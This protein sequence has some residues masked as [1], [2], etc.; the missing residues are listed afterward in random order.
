MSTFLQYFES[1]LEYMRHALSEFERSHP[2][3]AKSLRLTAGRSMDP[4]VQRLADSVALIAARL[5]KRLD[6]T[7]PEISLDILRMT[8]PGFL[9][10]APSYATIQPDPDSEPLDGPETLARGTN[11][12]FE[13]SGTRKCTFSVA[14]NVSLRPLVLRNLRFEQAPFTF[15]APP[16]ITGIE[17]ALCLEVVAQSGE[18]PVKPLIHG[19]LEIYLPSSSSR[20]NSLCEALAGAVE[21]VK[22]ATPK[23]PDGVFLPHGAFAPSIS[24][25][26]ASFLPEFLVQAP[27]LERLRDYL[28]YPDKGYFFNFS[29]LDAVID[30]QDATSF[31]IRC[32]LSGPAASELQQV[33]ASD[34]ALNVIP[35]LNLFETSSEPLR[36]S[37]ARDRIPVTP[38]VSDAEKVEVLR[39]NAVKELTPEGDLLLTE[40]SAPRHH[41]ETNNTVWQERLNNGSLDPSRREVSFSVSERVDTDQ[42]LDIVAELLCSNGAAGTEPRPGD[43]VQVQD[44]FVADV[45]FLLLDEPTAPISPELD[46]TR[47][48]DLI[49]LINGNFG[50]I[51]E[52]DAPAETLRETLH[53]AAPSGFTHAANAVWEV[54]FSRSIAPIQIGSNVLLASGTDVEVVLDLDALPYPP[55]VFAHVLDDF[56]GS[57]V[58]Y[59]RFIRLR[60]R[61]RGQDV[62]LAVFDRRHGSQMC[63]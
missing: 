59:D 20:R 10:G 51:L 40:A 27:G 62:P 12:V 37:F 35:C 39:I 58:S 42:P 44:D 26:P 36:Y 45:T 18:S 32:L 1:E 19:D 43:P 34:I 16:G 54:T 38:R 49:A 30:D 2:Q 21:A 53:I 17:S 23:T 60:V 15:K 24:R 13:N 8:C 63:G 61:A 52:S 3:K 5:Q 50:A 48:W 14:R 55:V 7:R 33:T 31:E 41:A 28:A 4:N 9:L 46:A 29:D 56:F 57:L 25:Q 22:V 6:D 11:I 47:Q